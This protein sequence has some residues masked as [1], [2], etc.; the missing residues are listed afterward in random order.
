M[1]KTKINGIELY[2]EVHGE[3]FPVVFTHGFAGTTVS[4]KPQVPVLSK[5]HRFIVYDARG[6]GQS[7][8]S[9]SPDQYSADIAVED[10]H[11][12]LLLLGVRK[13]VVGG[14]SMGGYIS[15]RFWLRHPEM[16][17]ALITMGTG[18]GYRNP[19]RMANWNRNRG[20]RAKLIE[21]EGM[22]A[23]ADTREAIEMNRYTPREVMLK[24]N[25]VG[26]AHMCRKVVA[27][28]DT[29]VIENIKNIRVPTL[30]IAGEGDTPFHVSA[31]Y[32]EKAIPGA[33]R[34]VIPKAGHAVNVDNAGEFNRAVLEFLGKLN[35]K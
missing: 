4:W 11:Q 2:Y 23:Y 35:L 32:M 25:P 5:N 8:S 22:A 6:H 19:K 10:L 28:H 18:P 15:L 7:E 9:K 17:A 33:K 14:L 31:E 1:P 27:Q 12:L 20:D 13:A 24:Q 21:T 16:V 29:L 3:G 30:V 34:V 26:L